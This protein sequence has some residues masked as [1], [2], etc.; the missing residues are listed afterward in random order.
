MARAANAVPQS[1]PRSNTSQPANSCHGNGP[2]LPQTQSRVNTQVPHV[3]PR[4]VM[5]FHQYVE[6]NSTCVCVLWLRCTHTQPDRV[7]DPGSR[8]DEYPCPF[9]GRQHPNRGRAPAPEHR[10]A[11]CEVTSQ[12][13]ITLGVVLSL[14][15]RC[16]VGS[17]L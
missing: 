2:P 13:V 14:T 6:S 11:L 16:R 3:S 17:L 7:P 10:V 15:E 1:Q 8:P 12:V 4:R 9:P 5:K